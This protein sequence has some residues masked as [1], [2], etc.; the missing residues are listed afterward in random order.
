[1]EKKEGQK[2]RGTIPLKGYSGTI[3]TLLG[4]VIILASP[5]RILL[6]ILTLYLFVT[7]FFACL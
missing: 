6:V 1:M 2:S 3:G 5:N 7:C 4:F